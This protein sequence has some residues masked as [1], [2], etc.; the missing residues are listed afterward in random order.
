M[1][2][3]WELFVHVL[4]GLGQ[5]LLNPLLYAFVLFVYLHYRKQMVIERQLFSVR[6]H[7]PLAQTIRSIGM[8]VAGGA[9]A[10][11]LSGLLGIVVQA[12]DMWIIWFLAIGLALFRLRFLCLAYAAGVLTFLHSIASLWLEGRQMQGIGAV[13]GWFAEAQPVPLLALVAVLH[14]VE[15]LLIR[16]NGGRDASPMFVEG[17]RGRIIGAFQLHSFWLTPLVLLV[18]TPVPGENG[19]A[20]ALFPGWP[21]FSPESAI[22]SLGLLLL[23]A[24]TGFSDITQTMT[25]E[26]KARQLSGQLSLYSLVLLL[27]AYVAVWIPALSLVAA[28]FALVG[29]EGM[30][31]YSQRREQQAPPYFIQSPDGVKVMT[32]IPGS[33]AEEMGILPGEVIVKVNGIPVRD[34]EELYPALQAN[35]AFCKMEVLTYE[36]EIKFV[37]CAVYAGNHHQL[38]IIVV[39]DASTRYFVDVRKLSLVQLL[40]N[41]MERLKLGA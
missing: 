9:I 32:V 41:R 31:W 33:P 4:Y 36:R 2:N 13:W 24:M 38:G 14:L 8:G 34:K 6:L 30:F 25:P 21:L 5:F 22:A 23:P 12:T 15:A 16:W 39:P 11:V 40:K 10:S 35:P 1:A 20:G 18:Q 17:K 19:F 28:L 29:H 7:S 27:L 37:Q 3:G 26:R